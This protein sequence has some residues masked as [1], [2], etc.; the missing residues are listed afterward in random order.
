MGLRAEV[1]MSQEDVNEKR[2]RVIRLAIASAWNGVGFVSA[3]L[4]NNVGLTQHQ[5]SIA[6]SQVPAAG[7]VQVQVRPAK[8]GFW[9]PIGSINLATFGS[10]QLFIPGVYDGVRLTMTTALSAGVTIAASLASVGTSLTPSPNLSKDQRHRFIATNWA[11]WNGVGPITVFGS[12]THGGYA[13]HQFAITGGTGA[14]NLFGRPTGQTFFT[15]INSDTAAIKAAGAIVFFPG[16]YDAFLVEPV[17]TVSGTISMTVASV[18]EELPLPIWP[19]QL[20]ASGQGYVTSFNGRTG[21]VTLTAADV[22]AVLTGSMIDT[23][24][25]YTPNNPAGFT[26]GLRN[27]IINAAGQVNQLAYVSGTATTSANQYTLDMWKVQTS[28]QNLSWTTSGNIVTYTAPAGGMVQVIEG[29][30]ILGGNYVISWTG[31]ATCTVNGTAATSGS[32]VNLPAGT[33]ATVV[34]SSGTMSEPQLE[35]LKQTSFEYRNPALELLLCQR[36][37][38]TFN[39]RQIGGA[40]AANNALSAPLTWPPMRAVPT[41]TLTITASS[42]V[43]TGS[44]TFTSSSNH[45]GYSFIIA[46]AAGN[47]DCTYTVTLNARL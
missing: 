42:N 41:A 13:Q 14:V 46:T 27:L 39:V 12:G 43:T 47:T 7:V 26:Y 40:A 16:M 28:G 10:G 2:R 44:S 9:V 35:L 29:P 18:G 30:L 38:N 5:I 19:W 37:Y 45:C 33:N 20:N 23:A 36:Y 3:N 6:C 11:S 34:W 1:S 4:L 17:G 8:S 31:T 15:Q 21:A 24:L 32:T 22:A 25:G